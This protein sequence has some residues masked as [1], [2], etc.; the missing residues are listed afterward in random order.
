MVKFMG[1]RYTQSLTTN[2]TFYFGPKVVLLY[3]AASFL[4]RLFPNF[5]SGDTA[6]PI[7]KFV[8]PF[9]GANQTN[10]GFKNPKFI[11]SGGE[12]FPDD[13]HNRQ[14]PLTLANVAD[15]FV[16]MYGMAPVLLGGN[17]GVN[18]FDAL[19]TTGISG[20]TNGSFKGATAQQI[21]CL[22][23]QIATENL[24]TTVGGT[25]TSLSNAVI[26]LVI[27]NL[28]PLPVFVGCPLRTS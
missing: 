23:Y 18:N 12:R 15:D 24:P 19:N 10:T 25:V 17:V 6:P 26:A 16:T 1:M 5:V 14:T 2:P 20:V 9:F 21:I 7:L 13:W 27:K 28:N 4:F 11:F 8:A 3:G 22:F